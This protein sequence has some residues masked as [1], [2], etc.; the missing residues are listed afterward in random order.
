MQRIEQLA[1]LCRNKTVY[2]QT[3]NFPDPDAIASA[4]GLQKLL[5]HYGV[6]STL[7]YAG[8]IDKLSTSK[9]LQMFR[10]EMQSYDMLQDQI[11]I[12]IDLH[13]G[14]GAATA[15]GCDLTYDYVKINGDYRT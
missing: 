3:H 11:D 10:I 6:E 9:M 2:I 8:R 1:Q 4:F 14:D 7:C 15:W 5:R 13:D 12:V